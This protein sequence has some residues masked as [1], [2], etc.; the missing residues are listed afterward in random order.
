MEIWADPGILSPFQP[1]R[2]PHTRTQTRTR[3]HTDSSG[4]AER[5]K[6]ETLKDVAPAER[7]GRSSSA[8]KAL[9]DDAPAEQREPIE[10]SKQDSEG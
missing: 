4:A 9:K 8:I 1:P 6:P 3:K 10:L 2:G 5:S 7:E